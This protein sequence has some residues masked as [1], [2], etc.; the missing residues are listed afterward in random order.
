MVKTMMK[1]SIMHII[2]HVHFRLDFYMETSSM[3][4]D[5]SK[6][7]DWGPYCLQYTLLKNMSRREEQTTKVVTGGLILLIA[8]MKVFRIITEFG[9]LR[10]T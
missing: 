6:Q 10:L 3:S 2:F 5:Q 4:P 1:S 9:I 8:W 7:S